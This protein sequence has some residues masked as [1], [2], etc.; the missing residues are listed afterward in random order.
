MKIAERQKRL[1]CLAFF[2]YA[3]G[4]PRGG[5]THP[6]RAFRVRLEK[7]DYLFSYLSPWRD[8]TQSAPAT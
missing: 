7:S 2:E 4:G 1:S 3:Q 8:S 6:P 5:D